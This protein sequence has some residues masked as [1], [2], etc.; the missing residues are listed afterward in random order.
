MGK[1]IAYI[2]GFG[3]I[4]ANQ[5]GIQRTTQV[6]RS[7]FFDELSS[8]QR[9][10]DPEKRLKFTHFTL[11]FTQP[12]ANSPVDLRDS[13]WSRKTFHFSFCETYVN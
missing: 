8:D 11:Y 13:S 7:S 5:P 6:P 4:L 1:C 10:E 3:H 9:L 12:L 2:E